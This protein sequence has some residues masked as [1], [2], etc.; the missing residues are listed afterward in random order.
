MAP[1]EAKVTLLLD[2]GTTYKY[3]GKLLFADITVDPSTGMITLRAEFPNPDHILLPGMFA[4]VQLEQAMDQNAISVPQRAVALSGDGTASVM[5]V[6]ADNKVEPR[7]I[8]LGQ[9]IGN[10]WIVTDGLKA[11]DNVIVEGLQKIK[12]EMTVKPVPFKST[13]SATD[14]G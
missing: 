1:D 9:A 4:R 5:I 6:T 13:D 7:T 3:P 2:D 10:N 14:G 12:P 11:G 8:K